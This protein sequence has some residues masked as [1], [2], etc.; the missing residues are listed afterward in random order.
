MQIYDRCWFIS[1]DAKMFSTFVYDIRRMRT[2]TRC[3]INR[4]GLRMSSASSHQ[5]LPLLM[6]LRWKCQSCWIWV[7][8]TS[9]NQS[10]MALEKTDV[11][12]VAVADGYPLLLMAVLSRWSKIIEAGSRV[13]C[14]SVEWSTVQYS[15]VQR[16]TV[17]WN[18]VQQSGVQYST[19]R[20]NADQYRSVRCSMLGLVN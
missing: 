19:A 20:C 17:Q 13:L 2:S 14:N 1:R 16:C 6:S 8:N 11:G 9:D 5:M 3:W 10:Y 7:S 12:I 18:A 4:I 15:T